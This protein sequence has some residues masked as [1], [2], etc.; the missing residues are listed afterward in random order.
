M[1]DQSRW[2]WA[3]FSSNS[4][5]MSCFPTPR[6][7]TRDWFSC[8][9]IETAVSF[10]PPS[11]WRCSRDPSNSDLDAIF[12]TSL[13]VSRRGHHVGHSNLRHEIVGERPHRNTLLSPTSAAHQALVQWW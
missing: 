6:G 8:R 13:L 7:H 1:R 2:T 12:P 3:L 5:D 11:E 4:G 9:K 10:R